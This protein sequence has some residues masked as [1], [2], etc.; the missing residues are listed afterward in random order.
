MLL[1]IVYAG[2][3]AHDLVLAAFTDPAVCKISTATV[4]PAPLCPGLAWKQHTRFLLS[5]PGANT[6]GTGF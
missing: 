4:L 1:V 5:L 2:Q 3:L 6:K